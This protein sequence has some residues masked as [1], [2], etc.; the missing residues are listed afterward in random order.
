[1]SVRSGEHRIREDLAVEFEFDAANGAIQ[2]H[3]TPRLPSKLSP[4]ELDSYRRA[5]NR[6]LDGIAKQLGGRAMVIE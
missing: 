6:F 3:W 4:A 1:M 2:T 5:R